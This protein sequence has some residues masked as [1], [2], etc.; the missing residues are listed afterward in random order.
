MP[1]DV[2][3]GDTSSSHIVFIQP[4][5]QWNW[6]DLDK[7]VNNILSKINQQ[8]ILTHLLID[9]R[10]CRETPSPTQTRELKLT[11]PV[12]TQLVS[13]VIL[14]NISMANA[15]VFVLRRKYAINIPFYTASTIEEALKTIFEQYSPH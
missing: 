2:K 15:I 1:I 8:P 5:G 13:S 14:G 10:Q 7:V 12:P 9:V 6:L 4:Y 3:W 11:T